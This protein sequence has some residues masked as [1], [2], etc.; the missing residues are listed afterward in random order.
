MDSRQAKEIL[1]AYRPGVDDPTQPPF[2]EALAQ[3]ESDA[4]LARWF[5]RQSALDEIIRDELQQMPV[6]RDLRQSIL[7]EQQTARPVFWRSNWFAPVLAAASLAIA[8]L[9]LWLVSQH[10]NSFDSYRQKMV[11]YVAHGYE[12]EVKVGTFEELQNAF[13]RLGWPA[14]YVVP[15][16]MASLKV[17]GGCAE[18][19][20]NTKVSLLCLETSEEKDVW[21]F[22][23][24]QTEVPGAPT[25][26]APQISHR[27][28]LTTASWSQGENLYLLAVEGDESMLRQFLD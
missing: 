13:A 5:E 19:W 27:G 18:K 3:K 6:P 8:A 17:E 4:N 15:V 9:G 16:R 26:T 11:D 12:V 10:G 23:T 25:G 14:D 1:A 24:R 20:R 7:A 22:V 2:A 28:E 21:L